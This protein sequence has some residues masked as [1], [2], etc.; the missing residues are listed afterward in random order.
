VD[1]GAAPDGRVTYS[2]EKLIVSLHLP[3]TAGMSF[4]KSLGD[5]FGKD[6]LL[7]YEDAPMVKTGFERA[8]GALNASI[9]IADQGLQDYQCVH[10]H[11]LPVKYLL[12]STTVKVTFIT[13]VRDP[14]ERLLSHYFYW[15]RSYD[16]RTSLPHHRKFIEEK[17]SLERFCLGP[18]FRNIYTKY[19]WGFPLHNF[20]FIGVSEFYAD[21]FNFFSSAYFARKIPV[22][23]ENA[24]GKVGKKYE[25]DES[26]R[27]KIEAYH[28]EDMDI[29]EEALKAR[30]KR[31]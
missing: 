7:D 12:L 6:L 19:L 23:Q 24:G 3:K 14:V 31:A 13:W 28:Q 26:L 20:E 15:Q 4:S 17:W 16:P 21:D 11:F 25:I 29:Y 2:E 22:Y 30:A 8:R 10:G 27:K 18:E 5:Y 1:R 9:Q